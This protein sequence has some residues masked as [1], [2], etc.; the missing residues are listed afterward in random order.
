MKKKSNRILKKII[1]RNVGIGLLLGMFTNI[2]F[3]EI[4]LSPNTNQNT[5]ID[6]SNNNAATIIN[7]NTPNSKGISVWIGYTKLDKKEVV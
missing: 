4:R 7:I 6:R 3:G 2:M 5:T 1:K